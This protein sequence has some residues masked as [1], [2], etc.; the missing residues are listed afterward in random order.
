LLQRLDLG[1]VHLDAGEAA[2]AH[3]PVDGLDPAPVPEA[4]DE[5]TFELAP[6]FR[7][8]GEVGLAVAVLVADG[9]VAALDVDAAELRKVHAGPRLVVAVAVQVAKILVADHQPAVGVVDHN[10]LDDTA[11]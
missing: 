4:H 6:G 9:D 7:L 3:R 8:A 10:R 1:D 11:E 2:A 5:R